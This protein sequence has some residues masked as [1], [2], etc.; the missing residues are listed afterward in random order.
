MDD[1]KGPHISK[2]PL[3]PAERPRL[4]DRDTLTDKYGQ[5]TGSPGAQIPRNI[6]KHSHRTQPQRET[7]AGPKQRWT[8]TGPDVRMNRDRRQTHSA[9]ESSVTQGPCKEAQTQIWTQH[10]D[11]QNIERHAKSLQQ[12]T[13]PYTHTH[14]H[15]PTKTSQPDTHNQTQTGTHTLLRTQEIALYGCTTT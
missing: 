5:G 8:D 11:T 6:H 9:T 14:T 13:T 7:R 4:T 3:P 12:T 15:P 2:L 10:A 1:R